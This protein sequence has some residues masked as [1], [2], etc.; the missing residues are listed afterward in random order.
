MK[1]LFL[2]LGTVVSIATPI[3]AVI[4]CGV[5]TNTPTKENLEI[6][7]Y[8]RSSKFINQLETK[9]QEN[10]INGELASSFDF[11]ETPGDANKL[12]K[13]LNIID[14]NKAGDVNKKLK[15]ALKYELIYN[16]NKDSSYI[17]KLGQRILSLNSQVTRAELLS[18]GLLTDYYHG[19]LAFSAAPAAAGAKR[20]VTDEALN[21]LFNTKTLALRNATYKQIII[22]KYLATNKEDWA[23]GFIVE[24][25]DNLTAIDKMIDPANFVLIRELIQKRLFAK[26]E[27]SL[28]DDTGKF[29]NE[30]PV[31]PSVMKN[32]MKSTGLL[33]ALLTR[34]DS[35]SHLDT[36]LMSL[37][38]DDNDLKTLA[39]F[40]GIMAMP[41]SIKDFAFDINSFKKM[42]TQDAW[43]GF[44]Q[45]NEILGDSATGKIRYTA[46]KTPNKIHVTYVR[47]LMPHYYENSDPTAAATDPKHQRLILDGYLGTNKE[48]LIRYLAAQDRGLY[49]QAVAYYTTKRGTVTAKI[50]EI[51][52]KDIYNILHEKGV[53]FITEREQKED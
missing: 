51:K 46:E 38:T 40:K 30:T 27:I 26:W 48:Q 13:G 24:N 16:V 19:S 8:I 39:A 41:K 9:W 34:S 21:L 17:R 47:G 20:T 15:D 10:L 45:E 5:K 37:G 49:D 32:A 36:K 1:K 23:K 3:A 6:N 50:L 43:N 35:M 11:T 18:H 12:V 52:N 33:G 53:K 2:S 44:V 22:E 28:D 25:R 31:D 29:F 4:S 14:I 42:K 7:N